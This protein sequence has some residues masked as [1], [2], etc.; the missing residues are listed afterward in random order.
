MEHNIYG[1]IV[2]INTDEL[3]DWIQVA[4]RSKLINRTNKLKRQIELETE[5][6]KNIMLSDSPNEAFK[7]AFG[8]IDS[9]SVMKKIDENYSNLM[10]LEYKVYNLVKKHF[11]NNPPSKPNFGFKHD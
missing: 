3:N 11:E 10:K 1:Y 5:L 9:Q 8:D 7:L 6:F 2:D 4:C